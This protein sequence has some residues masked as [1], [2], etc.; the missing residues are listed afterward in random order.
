M[1]TAP[2]WGELRDRAASTLRDAGIEHPEREATWLLE[3]ISGF[4][5]GEHAT[6][7]EDQGTE[8]AVAHLERMLGQRVAGVPLQY[9][10]GSWSFRGIDLFVDP[11]VLI[12]RPETEIVAEYAIDELVRL[13]ATRDARGAG[14][15]GPTGHVAA[16][17]GTGSG[18]IAVA[19]ASELADVEVWATDASDDALAVVRQQRRGCGNGRDADSRRARIVVRR[20]AGGAAGHPVAARVEPAL[21]RGGRARRPA[22]RRP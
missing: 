22:G 21:H 12:P 18:A 19:L 10:L 4:P 14:R 11:R 2:T 9:A 15:M 8:L 1:S 3:R 20:A 16:D 6:I 13:G 5:A 7:V 17:L